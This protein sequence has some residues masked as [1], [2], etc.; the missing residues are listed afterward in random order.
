M[1]SSLRPGSLPARRYFK[2]DWTPIM[3]YVTDSVSEHAGTWPSD[4]FRRHLHSFKF[5]NCYGYLDTPARLGPRRARVRRPDWQ[6][7]LSRSQGPLSPLSPA[8]PPVGTP[9]RTGLRLGDERDRAHQRPAM[10]W[11]REPGPCSWQLGIYRRRPGSE[12]LS[13]RAALL[14]VLA[15]RSVVILDVREY[16]IA[17]ILDLHFNFFIDKS[18][19][20]L[21]P[22][23]TFKLT[24]KR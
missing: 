24:H 10:A 23:F 13:R 19:P 14:T 21:F 9:K 7:M 18:I 2:P 22:S 16:W 17:L 6:Y 4:T 20:S 5:P 12:P 3:M 8:R 11:L 1:L 15:G